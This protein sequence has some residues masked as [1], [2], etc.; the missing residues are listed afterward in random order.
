MT[1]CIQTIIHFSYTIQFDS[2]ESKICFTV[3][4]ES[5]RLHDGDADATAGTLSVVTSHSVLGLID[6]KNNNIPNFKFQL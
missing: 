4:S 3:D 6:D 2:S 5:L 1:I